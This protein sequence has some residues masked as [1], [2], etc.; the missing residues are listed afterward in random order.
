[1]LPR[2][3]PGPAASATT[4]L[5]TTALATALAA[6]SLPDSGPASASVPTSVPISTAELAGRAVAARAAAGGELGA[7]AWC[8]ASAWAR[9]CTSR[10]TTSRS[11]AAPPPAGSTLPTLWRSAA[12]RLSRID[13]RIAARGRGYC[14]LPP[15]PARSSGG[16]R[17]GG[18]W[19]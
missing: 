13:P 5:A 2:A 17:G 14:R 10:A 19:R 11:A 1:M 4:T 7:L 8:S 6:A 18:G 15:C 12:L 3:D 9:V 16:T